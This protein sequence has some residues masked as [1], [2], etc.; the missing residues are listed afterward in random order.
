MDKQ[1]AFQFAFFL[2]SWMPESESQIDTGHSESVR[3]DRSL[4]RNYL[5]KVCEGLSL[6]LMK[7]A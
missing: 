4:G 6:P 1:T 7:L 3:P 5:G 2:Y